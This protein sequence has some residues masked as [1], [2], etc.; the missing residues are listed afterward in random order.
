MNEESEMKNFKAAVGLVIQ[1]YRSVTAKLL[2]DVQL[3]KVREEVSCS[4][5]KIIQFGIRHY[6]VQQ[7]GNNYLS[8][9]YITREEN[10]TEFDELITQPIAKQ[11]PWPIWEEVSEDQHKYISLRIANT[12]DVEDIGNKFGDA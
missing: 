6:N 1:T 2:K 9:K 10:I 5:H 4:D 3:W 12:E 7:R 8:I 11:M